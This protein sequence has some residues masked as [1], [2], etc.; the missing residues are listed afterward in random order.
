MRASQMRRHL[1]MLNQAGKAQVRATTAPLFAKS[2]AVLLA[3]LENLEFSPRDNVSFLLAIDAEIEHGLMIQYLYAAYSLGG[4]QVPSRYRDQVRG[5]QEVILGIAKE[6]MGHLMTVQ[7]VRQRK[8]P[9]RATSSV[10]SEKVFTKRP[11]C[12]E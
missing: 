3:D 5:W 10:A 8:A 1:G 9:F 6:E 7:G 11:L 4:L 2:T 12:K